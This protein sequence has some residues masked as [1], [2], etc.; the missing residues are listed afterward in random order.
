MALSTGLYLSGLWPP[1]AEAVRYLSAYASYLNLEGSIVSGRRS[2][3]D[4]A[5]RYAIG[6][7][8]DEV[9]RQV[10]K[11]IGIDVDT[12]APPGHS[13]HNY[14]LAIDVEGRNQAQLLSLAKQIGFQGVDGDPGHIQWPNWRPLVGL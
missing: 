1:M 4:Q 12:N 7:T 13:A 11:R 10:S 9:R 14:G 8:P 6:R 5:K 2:L 3:D